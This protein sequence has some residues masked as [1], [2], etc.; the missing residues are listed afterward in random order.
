MNANND[1]DF[2]IDLS[3]DIDF[4]NSGAL[5]D[6]A[7]DD[8]EPDLS[9]PHYG[10]YIFAL[11]LILLLV[12]IPV[13]VGIILLAA[14]QGAVARD[15]EATRQKIVL[16]NTAVGNAIAATKTAK[17]WTATPSNTP[18]PTNTATYTITPTYTLTF[19]TTYTPTST[20]TP[21][22]TPTFTPTP[23]FTPTI[24]DTPTITPTPLSPAEMTATTFVRVSTQIA[25]SATAAGR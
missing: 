6:L 17:A 24:T 12:V 19:T 8:S 20:E 15:F 22:F 16:T 23:S 7:D 4:S 5:P 9:E 1:D 10:V 18:T 13:I 2:D 3:E 11:A 14:S 21:T 25:A